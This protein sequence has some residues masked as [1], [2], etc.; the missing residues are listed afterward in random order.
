MEQEE[1]EA[2]REF[3]KAVAEGRN[4]CKRWLEEQAGKEIENFEES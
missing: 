1:T 4:D 2:G 3:H